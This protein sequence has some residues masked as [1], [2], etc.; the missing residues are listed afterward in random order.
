M[1]FS[2]ASISVKLRAHRYA[3]A[4]LLLVATAAAITIPAN[5]AV[6]SESE[7]TLGVFP[8]RNFTDTLAMYAPLAEYLSA[9]LKRPVRL[10]S[11][12]NFDD[13]WQGV[14]ERRY[15]IVHYNQYHYVKSHKRFGYEVIA[16]NEEFGS[17]TIAGV[18]LAR[19]D[20]NVRT[21]TDLRGKT[22]VFGGGRDAMQSYIAPTYL[23]RQ[24]GLKAGDYTERFARNPPNAI[25]AMYNDE[26]LAAGAA[27][28]CLRE[29]PVAS[30]KVMFLA[31]SE[32]MA[33]L[34]WAVKAEMPLPLRK[35]IQAAMTGL[36]RHPGGYEVLERARLTALLPASDVEY[37]PARRLI[38]E[39][40]AEDY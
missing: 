27:D 16:K 36:K 32:P 7:L 31:A 38:R 22:I 39:I 26:A 33:Q 14:T 1:K 20:R 19:S 12:K 13:F 4:A 10:E 2:N 11:A 3:I 35:S 25:L 15:D 18:L 29:S 9:Q 23:L 30:G 28:N 24:A 40:L 8:R 37:D 34:P 6:A 21:L 5:R 17:G